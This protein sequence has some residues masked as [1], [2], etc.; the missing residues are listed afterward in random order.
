MLA[1]SKNAVEGIL[2]EVN[3]MHNRNYHGNKANTAVKKCM[4]IYILTEELNVGAAIKQVTI[5]ILS[6]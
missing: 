4:T 6:V 5:F 2:G 1:V 3:K